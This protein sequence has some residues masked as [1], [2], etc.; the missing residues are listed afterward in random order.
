M[1]RILS[2]AVAVLVAATLSPAVAHAS[3]DVHPDVDYA[4]EAVPG[5]IALSDTTVVWPELGMTLTTESTSA[6]A[7]GNCATGTY[8]AYS[9]SG[10]SGSKLTFTI[11]TNVNTSALR[12]VGSIANGRSSGLVR[13][14]NSAATVLGTAGPN[15]STDVG[16]GTTNL[17]CTL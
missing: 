15:S 7:V 5:G 1:K 13:A 14:R 2:V 16:T 12:S 11:C 9:G 4:L 8:C 17:L 6:R 10:M 3:D